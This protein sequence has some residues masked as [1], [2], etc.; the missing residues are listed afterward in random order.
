[1]SN[2][3]SK[4][5]LAKADSAATMPALA[6]CTATISQN[7]T[8]VFLTKGF[9]RYDSWSFDPGKPIYISAAT[10]GLIT[11][12]LPSAAGN[13]DQLVGVAITAAIIYWDP[14]LMIVEQ[15]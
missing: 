2:S 7:A 1:M 10:G 11:K 9:V 12:T 4:M 15:N 6:F 13:Q 14:N 8:G 3:S 5:A